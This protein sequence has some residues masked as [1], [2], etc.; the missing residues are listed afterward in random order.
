MPFFRID[1]EKIIQRVDEFIEKVQCLKLFLQYT[2]CI[3]ETIYF[4]LKLHFII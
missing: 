1:K 2:V 4:F 3:S